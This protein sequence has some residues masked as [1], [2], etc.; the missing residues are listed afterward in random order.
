MAYFQKNSAVLDY[1]IKSQRLC[2]PFSITAG[3][4]ASIVYSSD[5]GAAVCFAGEAQT[6]AAAAIDTGTNFTTPAAA[7]GIF[8]M[9]IYNLGT[10]SKVH[11]VTLFGLSS[12]TA[13]I[14]LV[15]ASSTG[16]TASGNIAISIDSS[17]DLTA[18][19]LSATLCVDYIIS[20]A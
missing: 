3:A 1:R 10:V 12:G 16:V 15:G 18:V 8:G 4:A 9:L 17:L 14:T 6:A 13:A 2:V 20:K 11:N 19:N 7:T 5:L